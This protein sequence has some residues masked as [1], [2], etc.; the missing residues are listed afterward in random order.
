M[1][2]D[3][4]GNIWNQI[5]SAIDGGSLSNWASRGSSSLSKNGTFLAVGSPDNA[6]NGFDSGRFLFLL[7]IPLA[8]NGSVGK[9]IKGQNI[10]DHFGISIKLSDDG[11]IVA[12][13]ANGVDLNGNDAGQVQ[14]F[15]NI[16]NE[17]TQVGSAINGV[18]KK[19]LSGSTIDLSGDGSILAIGAQLNDDNGEDSGHVR[20][21][22]NKNGTWD[23]LGHLSLVN[24]QIIFW[25]VY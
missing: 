23:Q 12:I 6:E 20:I 17:W 3:T 21:F 15:E 2:T 11:S 8:I 9:D 14:I 7:S 1:T 25:I 22:K 10:G 13:G 24:M 19:D 5:G 4:G 16:A 18:S